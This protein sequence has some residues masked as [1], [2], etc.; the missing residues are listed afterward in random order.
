[1][2]QVK[3]AQIKIAY[4]PIFTF[5]FLIPLP[6][7]FK[8]HSVVPQIAMLYITCLKETQTKNIDSGHLSRPVYEY[9]GPSLSLLLRCR[10][11][12]G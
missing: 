2:F 7:L 8:F 10:W 1:M 3:T 9:L 12:H 5:F 6:S 4:N 11:H